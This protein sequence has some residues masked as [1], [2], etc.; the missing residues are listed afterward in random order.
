V[1]RDVGAFE[2]DVIPGGKGQFDVVH[3]E[4][5]IFSKAQA[6]RFPEEDEILRLLS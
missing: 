3:D 5:V 4:R 2:A 6:G 1:I